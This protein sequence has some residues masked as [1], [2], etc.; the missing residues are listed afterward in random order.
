[1]DAQIARIPAMTAPADG[2]GTVDPAGN[3]ALRRAQ[4]G[5]VS[6]FAQLVRTHQARIFSVALRLCGRRADAEELAQDVFVQLH[7]ALAQIAS[8]DHLRHWLLRAISHRCIDRLRSL[9]RRGQ[10]VPLELVPEIEAV[11]D[12]QADPLVAARLRRLLLALK[13]EARAVMLLRYQEDLD[14]A[15]IAALLAISVNTVKSHLRRSLD[16]MRAQCAGAEH[17]T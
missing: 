13:P 12:T 3:G 14:P 17:G 8:D 11:P 6:A 1:V 16:W 9:G 4:A 15:E 10:L 2:A 5:D 7:G